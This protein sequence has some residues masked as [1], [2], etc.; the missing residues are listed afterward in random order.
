M[1]ADS[2]PANKQTAQELP[3]SLTAL[4]ARTI[5]YAGLFP[6]AR[7]P[8]E[9]AFDNYVRYRTEPEQWMLSRFVLPVG[10]LDKLALFR[11]V[12]EST[13]PVHLSVLG[14]SGDALPAFLQNLR[15]DLEAMT[16]CRNDYNGQLQPDVMEIRLP[17]SL[18]A[19]NLEEAG[20]LIS[21]VTPLTEAAGL[22][23]FLEVPFMPDFRAV[24]AGLI[25][26]LEEEASPAIGIKMRTGGLEASMIPDAGD[27][28]HVI[29]R[30]RDAGVPFKATAGLHHPMRHHDDTLGVPMHGFFNLFGG[31]ALAFAHDLTETEIRLLLLEEDPEKL[32]FEGD[33]LHWGPYSADAATLRRARSVLAISFGSCSFDEPREDLR[34]LGL[35]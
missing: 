2:R 24:L 3:G 13:D 21:K 26:A 11:P 19:E 1:P 22:T 25:E 10:Q 20:A 23:L 32:E 15:S 4:L 29:A 35:L 16:T 33:T 18:T 9:E 7:L 34:A 6:P 17:S 30:C 8:L 14:S 27:V 5:D 28:A 31:A 12:I